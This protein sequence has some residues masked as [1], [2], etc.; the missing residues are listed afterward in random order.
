MI[1]SSLFRR[2]SWRPLDE[3]TREAV[4]AELGYPP[5]APVAFRVWD[6]RTE[7]AF[8]VTAVQ[9]MPLRALVRLAVGYGYI[10]EPRGWR[11]EPEPP[12]DALMV[13]FSR[14]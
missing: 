7:R 4:C 5:G 2:W 9:K 8:Y 3:L 1:F 13:D 6:G 11:S 14:A 10:R 12:H